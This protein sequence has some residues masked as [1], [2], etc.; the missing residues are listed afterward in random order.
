MLAAAT[1]LRPNSRKVSQ[2]SIPRT[3]PSEPTISAICMAVFDEF[4]DQNFTPEIDKFIGLLLNFL[5]AHRLPS[6]LNF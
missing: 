5:N 3:E 2:Q 1:S 6:L 4:W